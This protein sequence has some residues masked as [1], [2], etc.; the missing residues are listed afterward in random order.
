MYNPGMK[1]VYRFIRRMIYFDFDVIA[2]IINI[3]IYP[4]MYLFLTTILCIN[5]KK[6]YDLFFERKHKICVK[7]INYSTRCEKL[8]KDTQWEMRFPNISV[9]VVYRY[10]MSVCSNPSLPE[11]SVVRRTYS[12]GRGKK[13]WCQASV[14]S[15]AYARFRNPDT[16]GF[17]GEFARI[18]NRTLRGCWPY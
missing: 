13:C 6:K 3:Y 11:A 18:N 2:A 10:K 16:S 4:R 12:I 5:Q 14:R 9:K 1:V 15:G 17:N 7:I 8:L